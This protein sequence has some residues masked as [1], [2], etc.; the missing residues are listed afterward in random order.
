MHVRLEKDTRMEILKNLRNKR[1]TA[2]TK[3]YTK[4]LL[5]AI[6]L[7][8]P[9]ESRSNLARKNYHRLVKKIKGLSFIKEDEMFNG[10]IDK[11]SENL[12]NKTTPHTTIS[13]GTEYL[14]D[15]T[16]ARQ[17][18]YVRDI[19]KT[20]KL[21][22]Y[23]SSNRIYS[24]FKKYELKYLPDK[25]EDIPNLNQ[26]LNQ[27]VD[28]QGD[29]KTNTTA[30]MDALK[31]LQ[32]DGLT[33]RY[34]R[35]NTEG[36]RA[37]FRKGRRL[38]LPPQIKVNKLE[39]IQKFMDKGMISS[40]KKP[41]SYNKILCSPDDM[42]IRYYNDLAYGLLSAYRCAD[43]LHVVK[44]FILYYL[45]YSLLKTL[46]DKHKLRSISKTIEKYSLDISTKD[47]KGNS[48]EFISD[49]YV[50]NLSKKFL[51]SP[52]DYTTT[53][54]RTYISFSRNEIYKNICAVTSCNETTNIE[55]HHVRRLFRDLYF[56]PHS[57]KSSF[58]VKSAKGKTLE[59]QEALN[60]ALKRKQIPLCSK[61]H[62][63]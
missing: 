21:P 48:V 10:L 29:R 58:R 14:E 49:I 35:K 31:P 1:N 13:E 2:G 40:K 30:I 44:N 7:I 43:N 6:D 51:M 3:T 19:L 17:I 33:S 22:Y 59:G 34:P 12:V 4:D 23:K 5:E 54:K 27:L 26:I 28:K 32:K 37:A 62:K 16:I 8:L 55:I 9:E 61:H 11:I 39:L 46:A 41:Q 47:I 25:I 53:L 56:D 63:D 36:L 45:R 18:E 57:K 52:K 24:L 42:I 50:A 15:L 38:S 20:R 60:S